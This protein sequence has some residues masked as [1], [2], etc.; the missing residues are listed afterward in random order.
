MKQISYKVSKLTITKFSTHIVGAV[1]GAQ[2]QQVSGS[3][4]KGPRQWICREWVTE[5]G[6][7]EVNVN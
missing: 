3:G 7:N 2:A 5:L 4:P 6:L 1:F